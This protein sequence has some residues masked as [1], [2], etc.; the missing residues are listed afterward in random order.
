MNRSRHPDPLH[1]R[2]LPA[3]LSD[4]A[5]N[6]VLT[7][8]AR[9]RMM[10]IAQD[11]NRSSRVAPSQSNHASPENRLH[12]PEFLTVPE[13]SKLLRMSRTSVYR[14]VEQR[15]IR[16][17]RIGGTLRFAGDDINRYLSEQVVDALKN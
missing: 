10:P 1:R 13:V 2:Q 8:F 9:S 4:T 11:P 6:A 14:L 16:F 3:D 17:Y 12:F 5:N 7:E 15:R